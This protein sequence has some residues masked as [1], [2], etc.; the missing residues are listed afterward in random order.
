MS[1]GPTVR[2]NAGGRGGYEVAVTCRS[3]HG[4]LT[5]RNLESAIECADRLASAFYRMRD[6]KVIQDRASHCDVLPRHET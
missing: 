3:Q 4:N 1:A 2:I 6:A 5:A